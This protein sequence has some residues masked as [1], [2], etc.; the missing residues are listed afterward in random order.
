MVYRLNQDGFLDTALEPMV[1]MPAAERR[2]VDEATTVIVEPDGSRR[3]RIRSG[4][5]DGQASYSPILIRLLAS[6][7]VDQAFD[8]PALLSCSGHRHGG[9]PRP[10]PPL[11]G[12]VLAANAV[13]Y[14]VAVPN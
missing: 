7:D 6:S 13:A 3:S 11:S 9:T 8:R 2:K 12:H 10:K 1:E 5:T 4:Q 14:R